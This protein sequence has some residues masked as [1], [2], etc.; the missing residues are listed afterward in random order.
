MP[1]YVSHLLVADMPYVTGFFKI[2]DSKVQIIQNRQQDGLSVSLVK[3]TCYIDIF[4]LTNSANEIQVTYKHTSPVF[5]KM[6]CL[7][8]TKLCGPD[9]VLV[10]V[11]SFWGTSLYS[12]GSLVRRFVITRRFVILNRAYKLIITKA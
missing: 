10:N 6:K 11:S 9:Y 12:E 1:N 5:T 7:E 4:I 3:A 2:S 8:I